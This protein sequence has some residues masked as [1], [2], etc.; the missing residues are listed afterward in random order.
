LDLV[1]RYFHG[2]VTESKIANELY[3]FQEA[4]GVRSFAVRFSL[5]DVGG[6]YFSYFN[7]QIGKVTHEKISNRNG[8]WPFIF[9]SS[10]L[11]F[12]LSFCFFF[13][14]SYISFFL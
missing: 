9:S 8:V 13:L 14:L 12:F 11:S 10:C 2:F 1:S 5:I 6:F 7:E 4:K 3:K